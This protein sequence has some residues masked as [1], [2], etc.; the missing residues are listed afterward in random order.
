MQAVTCGAGGKGHTKMR[1]SQKLMLAAL[2]LLVAAAVAGLLL[3]GS[4]AH[5]GPAAGSHGSADEAHL[6][7]QHLLTTA[8]S[9]TIIATTHEERS[10]AQTAVRLADRD[11]DLAFSDAL[12]NASQQPAPS[13]GKVGALENR[14]GQIQAAIATTNQE[15]KAFKAEATHA[16]GN[17]LVYLRGRIEL[18]QAELALDKDELSDA[19]QDL[20]SAG[21]TYNHLED[22][23]RQHEAAQH[24]KDSAKLASNTSNRNLE[25][26]VGGGMVAGWR[27]WSAFHGQQKQL[28]RAAEQVSQIGQRLSRER[29]ALQQ[30]VQA[31][32][33]QKEDLAKNANDLLLA[34]QQGNGA[35]PK[36]EA[37]TALSLLHQLSLD[38]KAL[39]DLNNRILDLQQLNATYGDWIGLVK[40]QE[41]A[42]L[43]GIVKSVLWIIL[44]G[45]L[46]FVADRSIDHAL[47]RVKL[48][49]KQRATLRA[50]AHFTVRAL[51]A[52]AVLLII[53]GPP[54]HLS[55]IVGLAGAGLTVS[56][57]D[58]IVSFFGWF[59]LMSRH[60]IR[61]G[62]WVEINGVTGEVVDVSLFRTVLMET[63]NWNEPGHPTGREVSFLNLYAV[64]GHYFNFTTSGQWLWDEIKLI[65]P[66]GVDPYPIVA[67]IEE[68]AK[69]ETAIN[70]REA[71]QE[72]QRTTR[73]YTVKSFSVAPSINL[74]TVEV[75]VE[76]TVQYIST[77]VDRY[78]LR[79][80]LSHAAVGLIQK[81]TNRSMPAMDSNERPEVSSSRLAPLPVPDA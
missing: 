49:R 60:G 25:A 17:R 21:G 12:R 34:R 9:L 74:R 52:L 3:T 4:T 15:I 8:D 47:G 26:G 10:L 7:D 57:K 51:T 72:W 31:E 16:R 19:N 75:G 61:A 64:E 11:V 53:L 27:V 18:A 48:E 69:A 38:E 42:A 71:E 35:N 54:D 2:L 59:I 40:N 80:K 81:G 70:A 45:L 78:H 22:L 44:A 41:R 30:H 43:H 63:G 67:K 14:V 62:D 37:N 6:L 5:N 32:E 23:W 76:V 13:S 66:S 58:F 77:A 73:G 20:T 68:T 28:Q 29:Q 65:I 24:A 33:S 1:R 50:V 79:L 55:T 46:V 56:L 36:L 39:S